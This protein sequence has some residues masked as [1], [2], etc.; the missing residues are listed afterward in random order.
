[1]STQHTPGPWIAKPENPNFVE[2]DE[3]TD[4]EVIPDKVLEWGSPAPVAVCSFCYEE[5]A[6]AN[7]RLIAA[8]P[9]LLAA[10]RALLTAE[11]LHE[12]AMSANDVSGVDAANEAKWPAVDAA[13]AA[14]AKATGK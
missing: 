14:I 10:L 13:H 3:W 11:M 6:E 9:D 4:F 12:T 7:A 2:D 5:Q 1:M 8:A